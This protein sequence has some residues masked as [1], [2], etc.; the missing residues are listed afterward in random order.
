MSGR[1]VL[2]LVG[3]CLASCGGK[4][5]HDAAASGS[6]G[7]AS[8]GSGGDASGAGSAVG[9]GS[10]A[11][12]AG[13]RSKP[14]CDDGLVNGDETDVDCGGPTC[15]PCPDGSV[16][17]RS[18]DCQNHLCLD[19]ACEP[20]SCVDAIRNGDET[21]V[22][23]GGECLP[24]ENGVPASESCDDAIR[25]F[26]ETDVDCG[27]PDCGHC[28]LG[29]TCQSAPDCGGVPCEGFCQQRCESAETDCGDD[30]TC[31]HGLCVYCHQASDCP[32]GRCGA[33]RPCICKNGFCLPY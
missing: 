11:G 28:E 2:V 31:E 4:Q 6:S 19:E 23:C 10:A 26:A 3:L 22:D 18:D 5:T 1:W 12:A 27:G 24:C 9:A 21:D 29:Q 14:S 13:E 25:N 20:A 30:A 33:N 16:C 17:E 7:S 8:D 15:T 32:E